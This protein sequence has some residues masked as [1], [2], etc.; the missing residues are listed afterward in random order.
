MVLGTLHER[1]WTRSLGYSPHNVCY[2][3]YTELD[4]H[5][6]TLKPAVGY[7]VYDVA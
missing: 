6:V 2:V 1:T 4:Y 5:I 3:I 7:R